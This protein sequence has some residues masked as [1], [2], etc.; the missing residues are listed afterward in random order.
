MRKQVQNNNHTILAKTL[1]TMLNHPA[2]LMF[3]SII[4]CSEDHLRMVDSSILINKI[5]TN[6]SNFTTQISKTSTALPKIQ[7][8]QTIH[9]Q[10]PR[11]NLFL[12]THNSSRKETKRKWNKSLVLL[13]Q[14]TMKSIMMR[15]VHRKVKRK[16]QEKH[17]L[18]KLRR[19]HRIMLVMKRMVLVI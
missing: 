14:L 5:V 2:F 3:L 7:T 17:L 12:S 1:T 16:E 11:M 15:R 10:S 8:V 6:S 9:S 13:S 4:R 18:E 19:R